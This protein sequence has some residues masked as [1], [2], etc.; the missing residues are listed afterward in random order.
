MVRAH[1]EM[2]F[3]FVYQLNQARGV[4]LTKPNMFQEH[5]WPGLTK[6]AFSLGG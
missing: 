1:Q 2:A 5:L 6:K 4:V 3:S